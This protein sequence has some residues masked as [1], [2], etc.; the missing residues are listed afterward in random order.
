LKTDFT[1][2]TYEVYT[3]RDGR[4]T[5][6]TMHNARWRALDR[7]EE[8]VVQNQVSAVK[9]TAE[10]KG[11]DIE[12]KTIF[13][14]KCGDEVQK[15]ITISPVN[16]APLCKDIND[17][18]EFDAR[19]T[20]GRL[21]REFLDV[22]EITALELLFDYGHLKDLERK[23]TLVSQAVHRIAALQARKTDTKPAKIINKLYDAFARI[24]EVANKLRGSDEHFVLLRNT[25]LPAFIDY[26]RDAS[27]PEDLNLHIRSAFASSLSE[28]GD[29]G[30]KLVLMTNL[31]DEKPHAVVLPFIDEVIAEILDCGSALKE[32]LSHEP[33]VVIACL[34]LIQL[35]KGNARQTK[36]T[37]PCMLPINT[38]I[39]AQQL[40]LT[41][42]LLLERIRN[43]IRSVKPLANGGHE[44]NRV[45]LINIVRELNEGSGLVGGPS[46]CE[47]ITLRAKITLKHSEDDLTISESIDSVLGLLPDPAVRLGYLIDLSQSQL[48]IKYKPVVYDKLMHME[49]GLGPISSLVP[50]AIGPKETLGILSGVMRRLQQGEFPGPFHNSL[51]AKIDKFKN[52]C[53]DAINSRNNDALKRPD[54]EEEKMENEN[55]NLK[56]KN[57][58]AG[59]SIFLE[60]EEADCA[61]L[62]RSG[63]VEIS[64][65]RDG[66]RIILITLG[67]NQIFGE[68]ALLESAPRSASATALTDCELSIVTKDSLDAQVEGLN[69]FMKYWLLYLGER[70]RDLTDRVEKR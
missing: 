42:N 47:A 18:Y 68:L 58:S 55:Q 46:M 1:T 16:D 25:G 59:K 69:G 67:A 50:N 43:H 39:A 53:E 38:A 61:Y 17:Y 28:A 70:I 24:I 22:R 3:L 60:G 44:E 57:V 63:N 65:V 30:G 8:L 54:G 2:Y 41:K 10:S 12:G 35:S 48:D 15:E 34:M 33:E 20:T 45:A 62:L 9:V 52:I 5:L 7:A 6:D 19:Q 4:W 13:E 21:L 31:L 64:T 66:T 29:F 40:P 27:G 11:G 56:Q 37:H 51:S 36:N 49:E 23:D 14:R 26:L 32:L